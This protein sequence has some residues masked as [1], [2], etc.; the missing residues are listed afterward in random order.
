MFTFPVWDF[1]NGVEVSLVEIF[2]GNFVTFQNS[3]GIFVH[4]DDPITI[5]L[6]L[7]CDWI[8]IEGEIFSGVIWV[9]GVYGDGGV[10][11]LE[12]MVCGGVYVFVAD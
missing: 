6:V 8:E 1:F 7:N 2:E 3:E 11:V 12:V 9:G 4:W 5:K 10:V